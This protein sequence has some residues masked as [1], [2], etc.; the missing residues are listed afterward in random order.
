MS[1]NFWLKVKEIF[2]ELD[3]KV[4]DRDELFHYLYK[5]GELKSSVQTQIDDFSLAGTSDFIEKIIQVV[6]RRLTISKVEQGKF[7]FTG[8]DVLK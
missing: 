4:M 1:R 2:L 6:S 3:L 7:R 5:D 8:L